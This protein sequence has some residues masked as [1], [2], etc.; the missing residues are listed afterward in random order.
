MELLSTVAGQ[1]PIKKVEE[2]ATIAW[3]G[4]QTRCMLCAHRLKDG[5]EQSRFE[6]H[7]IGL[8]FLQE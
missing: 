3:R 4:E 8:P 7:S 2:H 1:P 6:L 5:E